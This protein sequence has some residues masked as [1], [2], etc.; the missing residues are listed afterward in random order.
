VKL[1][2]FFRTRKRRITSCLFITVFVLTI[3]YFFLYY[4]ESEIVSGFLVPSAASLVKSDPVQMYEEYIWGAASEADSIPPY[5]W[6]VIRLWGWRQIAQ[7]GAMTIYEKDEVEMS[8]L[9][10]DNYIYVGKE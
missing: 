6:I 8:L 3:F 5:Y 9:S 2:S 10:F 7:E 1:S 4:Q